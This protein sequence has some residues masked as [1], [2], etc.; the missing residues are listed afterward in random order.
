MSFFVLP[1]E[2]YLTRE[3][4]RY[5]LTQ[6]YAAVLG[7]ATSGSCT[8]ENIDKRHWQTLGHDLKVYGDYVSESKDTLTFPD[9]S[10]RI[11]LL[12]E[13]FCTEVVKQV[14]VW[15]KRYAAGRGHQ[16]GGVEVVVP[17]N[18][19]NQ[20]SND[21][22]VTNWLIRDSQSN[23]SDYFGF[24]PHFAGMT[25]HN[26]SPGDMARTKLIGDLF[27]FCLFGPHTSHV[28]CDNTPAV[29]Q[30]V[31]LTQTLAGSHFDELLE[32]IFVA[33]LMRC[34]LTL[35]AFS[36]TMAKL[37]KKNK[38]AADNKSS[39]QDD[40]A[41][42]A[43]F[44]DGDEVRMI[45]HSHA[46]T[47]K[48]A[49]SRSMRLRY[50]KIAKRF[51]DDTDNL[52]DDSP[53]VVNEA[54][55]FTRL[56]ERIIREKIKLARFKHRAQKK[57]GE[58][59]ATA[60]PD[61]QKPLKAPKERKKCW[62]QGED[63]FVSEFSKALDSKLNTESLKTLERSSYWTFLVYLIHHQNENS[64]EQMSQDE[65]D[66]LWTPTEAMLFE[67]RYRELIYYPLLLRCGRLWRPLWRS[68]EESRKVERKGVGAQR[69]SGVQDGKTALAGVK[70]TVDDTRAERDATRLMHHDVQERQRVR[71]STL[72]R[73]QL[74]GKVATKVVEKGGPLIQTRDK[75]RY[76]IM[77]LYQDASQKNIADKKS[78]LGEIRS[79]I[80]QGIEDVIFSKTGRVD[81]DVGNPKNRRL[82]SKAALA[83]EKVNL[84]IKGRENA[85]GRA[86]AHYDE[87]K[88]RAD[89]AKLDLEAAKAQKE[90]KKVE[91]ERSIEYYRGLKK[92]KPDDESTKAAKIAFRVAK[93]T[94]EEASRKFK[95]EKT[96]F[97]KAA[98]R[99][100]K[101]RARTI[102]IEQSLK[103][104]EPLEVAKRSL[105]KVDK[106]ISKAEKAVEKA[107][108]DKL[109]TSDTKTR[110]FDEL[111]TAQRHL[112]T[113]SN[114]F[115]DALSTGT[116]NDS[117]NLR[118]ALTQALTDTTT[119]DAKYKTAF[120]AEASSDRKVAKVLL[121]LRELKL[122]KEAIEAHQSPI[123]AAVSIDDFIN[124]VVPLYREL[125]AAAQENR[126]GSE[127][128][129]QRLIGL[130]A[131]A[132]L[133]PGE[134]DFEL[135]YLQRDVVQFKE[136]LQEVFTKT[137]KEN[138]SL[139]SPES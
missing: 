86:K 58:A 60:N 18:Q 3:K 71:S 24:V 31:Q 119:A 114:T 5:Y 101:A 48:I 100:E 121:K 128:T 36:T 20:F 75:E 124:L 61:R 98:T 21:S 42:G 37:K 132:D 56:V 131:D 33:I 50:E 64:F 59:K 66:A 52:T 22:K 12:I 106:E 77:Q 112:A 69:L 11:P 53:L 87:G 85:L 103:A 4:P 70:E 30:M 34:T 130:L 44:K 23:N 92:D 27:R 63:N 89:Q 1:F 116:L 107:R 105:A 45:Y 117:A 94:A 13:R 8:L 2:F 102:S 134:N 137:G 26:R 16:E 82:E 139:S 41:P 62:L 104:L 113:A 99:L 126:D 29:K 96:M 78:S 57:D 25:A 129:E 115:N 97:D 108:T 135:D 46:R 83:Q 127:L 91:K 80:E 79:G 14:G 118:R 32:N 125:H 123:R 93:A 17:V 65:F 39:P 38:N 120:R 95:A 72:A 88:G 76:N 55:G 74:L 54:E 40:D 35:R 110:A 47:E 90:T 6:G 51:E 133:R 49:R 15:L 122:Q 67:K 9:E 109:T 10:S 84:Q 138:V 7:K 28:E 68:A 73:S 19:F 136:S 111:E 43:S 81:L